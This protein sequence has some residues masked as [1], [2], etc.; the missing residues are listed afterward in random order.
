MTIKNKQVLCVICAMALTSLVC[1][2][3]QGDNAAPDRDWPAI[4][5]CRAQLVGLKFV[6][7]MW[8][9]TDVRELSELIAPDLAVEGLGP[10]NAETFISAVTFGFNRM[11]KT[12]GITTLG[13]FLPIHEIGF[14]TEKDLPDL[15]KRFLPKDDL[16]TS[17]QAP[18]YIKGGLG[19]YITA[20][21]LEN[22][23]V[24]D[25]IVYVL[26]IKKVGDKH[27]VIYYG[28]A[29]KHGVG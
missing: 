20:N 29:T 18:A 3:T 11:K 26:I 28:K 7:S 22:G 1:A 13:E 25:D 9:S 19:C 6:T 15:Q 10:G 21:M 2:S 8:L 5:I 27:R 12:Q 17:K 14:F 16:W 4:D 24:V 23:K